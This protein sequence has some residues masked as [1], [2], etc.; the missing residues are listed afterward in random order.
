MWNAAGSSLTIKRWW[1]TRTPAR[2]ALEPGRTELTKMPLSFPP[3][4]SICVRRFSP[5]RERL[6]TGRNE[7][8]GGPEVKEGRNGL[9]KENEHSYKWKVLLIILSKGKRELKK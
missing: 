6:C 7:L 1:P 9:E 4:R 2:S 8:R 5:E 3:I